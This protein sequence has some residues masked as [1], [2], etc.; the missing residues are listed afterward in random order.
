MPFQLSITVGHRSKCTESLGLW[1]VD[2]CGSFWGYIYFIS[3][4]IIAAYVFFNLVIGVV[5]DNFMDANIPMNFLIPDKQIEQFRRFWSHLDPKGTGFI[6]RHKFPLLVETLAKHH[7]IL[8][9]HPV[10]EKTNF[11]CVQMRLEF[12]VG[13]GKAQ[14]LVSRLFKTKTSNQPKVP[15]SVALMVLVVN[16]CP[17]DYLDFEELMELH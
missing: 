5:L 1:N 9:V 15:F 4:F 12:N 13:Q 6:P 2:D 14:S 7:N 11:R 16:R 8:G 3:F 17:V 10:H